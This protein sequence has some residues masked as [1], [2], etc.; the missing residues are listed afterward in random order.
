MNLH[1]IKFSFK[2]L[3]LKLILLY[4]NFRNNSTEKRKYQ[5]RH[6]L[7]NF[8]SFLFSETVEILLSYRK[9]E[10]SISNPYIFE[11]DFLG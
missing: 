8:I 6:S 5:T 9:I 11:T 3:N 10:I 7:K 4:E 2:T 1:F